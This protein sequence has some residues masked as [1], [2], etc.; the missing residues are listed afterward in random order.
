MSNV[1]G[2]PSSNVKNPTLHDQIS[3]ALTN[4]TWKKQ[5][6]EYYYTNNYDDRNA[7]TTKNVFIRTAS[8]YTINNYKVTCYVLKVIFR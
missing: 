6:I 7:V 4:M 8:L 3:I 1:P 2:V 5:N